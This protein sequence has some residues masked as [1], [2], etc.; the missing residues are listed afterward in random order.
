[1][2]KKSILLK[3]ESSQKTVT[4]INLIDIGNFKKSMKLYEARQNFIL[5]CLL[6]SYRYPTIVF[7]LIQVNIINNCSPE[8][9]GQ[10]KL[11][12]ASVI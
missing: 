2:I 5:F 3:M 10:C 4:F 12:F 7:Y 11:Y 6:Y 9:S 1:M 8:R